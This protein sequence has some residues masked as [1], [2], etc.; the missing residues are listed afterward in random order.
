MYDFDKL[1]RDTFNHNNGI[2][3][4]ISPTD[5][6]RKTTDFDKLNNE[7]RAYKRGI[8]VYELLHIKNTKNPTF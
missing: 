6:L 5:G 7:T 8:S 1:N 4:N 3:R 2:S